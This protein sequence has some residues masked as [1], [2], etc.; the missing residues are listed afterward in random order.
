MLMNILGLPGHYNGGAL[1]TSGHIQPSW[2]SWLHSSPMTKRY[3]TPWQ[4]ALM[5]Y[6]S[7]PEWLFFN[8]QNHGYV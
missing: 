4:G 1:D 2:Q 5:P 7:W 6:H 3:P 8:C